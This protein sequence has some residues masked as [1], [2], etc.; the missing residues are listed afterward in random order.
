MDGINL[1]PLEMVFF[2]TNRK[3]TPEILERYTAWQ[4]DTRPWALPRATY[5][6]AAAEG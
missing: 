3:V 6:G 1:H 2:K 5:G 4:L